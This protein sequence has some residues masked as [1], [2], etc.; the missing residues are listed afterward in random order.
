MRRRRRSLAGA[1]LIALTLSARPAAG[2]V[3]AGGMVQDSAASETARSVVPEP[4]TL[5]LLGLGL[6]GVATLHRRLKKRR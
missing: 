1:M 2:W 6:F 5:I 3:G 4:A